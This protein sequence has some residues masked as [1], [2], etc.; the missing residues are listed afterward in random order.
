M[1]LRYAPIQKITTFVNDVGLHLE[2]SGCTEAALESGRVLGI[3][4]NPKTI[5]RLKEKLSLSNQK[6]VNTY[7]QSAILQKNL[8]VLVIDDFHSIHTIPRPTSSE[9]SRA[10]H[11][12]TAI[13]DIPESAPGLPLPM[14][15]SRYSV[16][17]VSS[18]VIGKVSVDR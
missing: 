5:R 3:C 15:L 11:L 2:L 7:I 10:V 4:P 16:S 12:A 6:Q 9:T 8:A 13:I 14:S 17:D 1:I 18:T